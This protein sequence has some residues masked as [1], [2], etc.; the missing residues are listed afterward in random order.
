[1]ENLIDTY[2]HEVGR[3]LPEITRV[4]IEKE[5][6]STIEDMLDDTS[7]TE[8]RAPDQAMIV[9]ILKHMGPP[10]K[11]AASYLP[12]RYLVGPQLY[13]TFMLVLRIVLTV[14]IILGGVGLGIA[15]GQTPP[16]P[17]AVASAVG[18][19]LTE[20]INALLLAVGN[21][22]VV[23]AIL[24][25]FLPEMKEPKTDW[26][27]EKMKPVPDADRFRP[28]EPV[29]SIVF[30]ILALMIFNLY[31]QLIG[32]GFTINGQW[33][34]T[35]I[36]AE[37]FF[38]VLP[39]LNILWVIDIIFQLVLLIRGRWEVGTRLVEVLL[40]VCRVGVTYLMVTGPELVKINAARLPAGTAEGMALLPDLINWSIRFGLTVA[41]IVMIVTIG[42]KIFKLL[43]PATLSLA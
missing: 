24:Q 28:F 16:T 34:F 13:P 8:G 40:D 17:S 1:M 5:I 27:P 32:I 21:I 43:R 4:D 33:V 35:P 22:V 26:D 15:L 29:V 20:L 37:G 31:P 30:T 3:H 12:P 41:L 9:A 14:V 2:V 10:E 7:K 11:L 23:F 18:N 42:V 38:K 25:R 6:R 36:L 39:W 19:S